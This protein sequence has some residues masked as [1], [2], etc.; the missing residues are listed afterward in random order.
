LISI[1]WHMPHFGSARRRSREMRLAHI[2]TPDPPG[3][4]FIKIA[5]GERIAGIP[6]LIA[7]RNEPVGEQ[8]LFYWVHEEEASATPR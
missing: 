7:V 8:T 1:G 2:A 3:F 4:F 5:C 6:R